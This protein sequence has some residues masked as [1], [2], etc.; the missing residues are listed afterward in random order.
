[1]R[2]R[3]AIEDEEVEAN[4]NARRRLRLFARMDLK[5]NRRAMTTGM[6]AQETWRT[7]RGLKI[8]AR[9]AYE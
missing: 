3:V 2:S 6:R 1:M 8:D 4:A 5:A 7:W 9:R